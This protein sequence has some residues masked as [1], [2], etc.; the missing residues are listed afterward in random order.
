MDTAG[1]AVA[2]IQHKDCV[3]ESAINVISSL[4]GLQSHVDPDAGDVCIQEV[5][6][7][8]IS[9]VGDV[10]WSVFLGLPRQTAVALSAKFAGFQIAF[11]A[12]EMGDAV[13][14]MANIFAGEVKARL[15]QKGVKADISLPSV[16]RGENL[17]LLIPK[18]A[19]LYQVCVANELGKLMV[20]VV[21]KKKPWN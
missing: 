2:D 9:L 5:M 13:G 19:P 15:D 3:P 21:A 8:V 18:D 11:E 4:C 10:E 16:M 1:T 17:R 14:E 7:A 20:G 6:L 12:D